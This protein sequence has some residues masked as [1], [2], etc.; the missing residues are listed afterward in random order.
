[1]GH[2]SSVYAVVFVFHLWTASLYGYADELEFCL[3]TIKLLPIPMDDK[4]A[5]VIVF[6]SDA[7]LGPCLDGFEAF[8]LGHSDPVAKT[9]EDWTGG[10][11]P[12]RERWLI[13]TVTLET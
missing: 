1:M 13:Y 3:S 6:T 10:Q 2:I 8:L 5:A 7:R 9:Y 4:I 11:G 12:S